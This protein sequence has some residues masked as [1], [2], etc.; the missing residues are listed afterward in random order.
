M[1]LALDESAW[2]HRVWGDKSLVETKKDQGYD[3]E[4]EGTDDRN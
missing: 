4:H 3:A 1:P 2:K